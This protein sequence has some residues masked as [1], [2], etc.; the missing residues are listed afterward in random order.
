MKPKTS[1]ELIEEAERKTFK[2]LHDR[3]DSDAA[4]AGLARHKLTNASGEE[5]PGGI[6]VTMPDP[7]IFLKVVAAWIMEAK[8]QTVV[9]GKLTGKQQNMIEGFLNDL[10]EDVDE[11]L[12]KTEYGNLL[13]FLASHICG[14]GWI[15]ARRVW[16]W[17]DKREMTYLDVVPIDMRYCSYERSKG[18]YDWVGVRSLR[19]KASILK[20]YEITIRGGDTEVEVV[21]WWNDEREEIWID[22]KLVPSTPQRPM[23]NTHR[24]G[25]PPFV[26]VPA[27]EGFMFL[28]RGYMTK[29]GESIFFLGR[30]TFEEYNRIVSIDQSLA[31][32][33]LAPPYQKVTSPNEPKSPY[34]NEP[35][36]TY[37][38]PDAAKYELI[39]QPD[40]NMA[41]RQAFAVISAAIQR[42]GVNNID[43][44]NISQPTSSIWITEQTEIRSKLIGPRLRAIAD[45]KKLSARMDIDQYQKGNFNALVGKQGKKTHYSATDLGDPDTYDILYQGMSRSKK[46][47]IA[48]M[49]LFN[50]SAGLSLKTR[51]KDILLHDDPD[52]EMVRIDAERAEEAD[53]ALFFFRKAY[54][55]AVE[56]QNLTGL[57]ADKTN[58]ES[59]MLV[60][61]GEELLRG[62]SEPTQIPK[63]KANS[64]MLLPLLG[65]KGM[66][67]NS[68]QEGVGE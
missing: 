67:G 35:G 3:M 68:Q 33:S 59:M 50:A 26:I 30:D 31:L 44:G 18:C 16:L 36:S 20:E 52:G 60:R 28:D 27:P 9:E 65:E 54:S 10:E 37:D 8:W 47:E 46:Q 24:I 62:A 55:L 39:P 6:S 4:L 13:P 29:R 56:A 11:R 43:L 53:P 64:N 12:S 32:L 7:G 49:A 48:N 2:G 38:L 66:K 45:F 41:G 42:V 23:P 61:K 57:E 40:I 14:R 5:V 21:D 34:P 22:K 51:L 25:Y 58:L 1:L 19:S 63:P 15:A 17:D